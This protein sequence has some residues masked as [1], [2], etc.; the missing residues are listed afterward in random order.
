VEN[1]VKKIVVFLLIILVIT[2]CSNKPKI[3]DT[4][5]NKMEWKKGEPICI[6]A[7]PYAVNTDY[8]PGEGF[9]ALSKANWRRF[10]EGMERELKQHLEGHKHGYNITIRKAAESYRPTKEC[11]DGDDEGYGGGVSGDM[12]FYEGCLTTWAKNILT[13]KE[14]FCPPNSNIALMGA[15]LYGYKNEPIKINTMIKKLGKETKVEEGNSLES[16]SE[17]LQA[18]KDKKFSEMGRLAGKELSELLK[19]VV[20]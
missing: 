11:G 19:R 14:D 16:S 20:E 18:A 7:M 17:F 12:N 6:I 15:Q 9:L 10:L 8:K 2:G 3:W 1:A 5:I 13:Q 4:M